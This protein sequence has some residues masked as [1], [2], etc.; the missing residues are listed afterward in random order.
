MSSNK[1]NILIVGSTGDFGKAI[2]DKL[3][4]KYNIISFDRRLNKSNKICKS[5]KL[6]FLKD[7]NLNKLKIILKNK[8]LSLVI[9]I[10]ATQGYGNKNLL[11]ISNKKIFD[12]FIVN[13]IFSSKLS[14]FLIQN[15]FVKKKT[16]FIYFSSR[17]GSIYERG[18]K[19][20]INLEEITYIEH[21]N[22]YSILLLKT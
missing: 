1:E 22:L 11:K 21:L 18:K 8:K 3:H 5:Y 12:V 4:K 19:N 17:S 9:F 20:I 7:F 6:N 16:S 2:I 15:N 14:Y 13:A 10:S